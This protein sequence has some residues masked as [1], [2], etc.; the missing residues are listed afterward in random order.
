MQLNHIDYLNTDP[1][2]GQ[3]GVLGLVKVVLYVSTSADS[4]GLRNQ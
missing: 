1:F 4:L 3:M 2:L